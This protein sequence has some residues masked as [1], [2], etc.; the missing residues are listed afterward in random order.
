M[1]YGKNGISIYASTAPNSITGSDKMTAD[2]LLKNKY[3]VRE[4]D[5][6]TH[7][8]FDSSTNPYTASSSLAVLSVSYDSED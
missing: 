1:F 2:R 3:R 7:Y 4:I 8:L 6:V 5:G